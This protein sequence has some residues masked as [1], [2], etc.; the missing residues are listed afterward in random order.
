MTESKNPY[1]APADGED[2]PAV[3][4]RSLTEFQWFLIVVASIIALRLLGILN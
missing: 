2:P 4:R 1:E 3:F